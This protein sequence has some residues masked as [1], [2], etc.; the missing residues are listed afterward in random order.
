MRQC[1]AQEADRFFVRIAPE[2]RAGI[3]RG[4]SAGLVAALLVPPGH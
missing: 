1:A 4:S 3:V 2:G